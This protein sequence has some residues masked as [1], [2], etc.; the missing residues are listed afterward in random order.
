[1]AMVEL[2]IPPRSAYVGV[3][4]LAVSSLARKAGLDEEVVDD[5]KI[6]VSEACTNAVEDTPGDDPISIRWME[7]DDRV[8]IEIAD[9]R[10]SSNAEDPL[11]TQGFST[12]LT[13]SLALLESLVDS[14]ELTAREGGGYCTRLVVNR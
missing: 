3:V 14:F 8:T 7:E 1:M 2:S 4:R 9:R 6:A 11:D 5:L 10:P 12:R 13:M